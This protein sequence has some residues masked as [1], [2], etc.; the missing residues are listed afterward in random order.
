MWQRP[1]RGSEEQNH[2]S[3]II[4]QAVKGH[5]LQASAH[6]LNWVPLKADP[7]TR[8]LIQ[9]IFLVR[10]FSLEKGSVRSRREQGKC[11]DVS[12]AGD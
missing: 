5:S 8:T 1:T 9:E 12:S 4:A 7:E 10:A 2:M 11:Q 6:V 3:K